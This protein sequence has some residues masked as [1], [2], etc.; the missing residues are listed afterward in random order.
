MP[1]AKGT[2][3]NPIGR[4]KGSVNKISA[5]AKENVQAVFDGLGG[6]EGMLKWAKDNPDEFYRGVY[7]RLLP[8]DTNVSGSLG[9]YTAIP[10]SERESVDAAIGPA[11][12]S[13]P[14]A[15]D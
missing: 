5:T 7:P 12:G 14:K 11:N 4:P 3:G 2:S 1:F 13:D 15:L 9:S 10:V 8:L 6:W